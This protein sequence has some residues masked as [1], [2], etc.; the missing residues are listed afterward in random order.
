MIPSS[1]NGTLQHSITDCLENTQ[2]VDC[3][4]FYYYWVDCEYPPWVTC[5]KKKCCLAQRHGREVKNRASFEIDFLI[6]MR[7]F[8]W[9]GQDILCPVCDSV[10]I[11][12]SSP[13]CKVNWFQFVYLEFEAYFD[14]YG[15]NIVYWEWLAR[16]I[17]TW[18]FNF[19]SIS[20]LLVLCRKGPFVV[21][22]S[23]L[24]GK[25]LVTSACCNFISVGTLAEV[26]QLWKRGTRW[27][28]KREAKNS[29]RVT[30]KCICVFC[31]CNNDNWLVL[32]MISFTLPFLLSSTKTAKLMLFIVLCR[33]SFSFYRLVLV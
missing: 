26:P 8:G 20:C 6:M 12:V 7:L 10:E 4:G 28:R 30:L 2:W 24:L 32:C 13:K 19:P 22:L 15:D 29:Q 21:Y 1:R 25:L 3:S 5:K 17:V 27:F 9:L 23:S 18:S 14:D 33:C 16:I 11:L 31:F